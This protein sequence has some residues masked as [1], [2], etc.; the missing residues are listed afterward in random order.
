MA[1]DLGGLS[2]CRLSVYA[3]SELFDDPFDATD[4]AAAEVAADDACGTASSCRLALWLTAGRTYYVA[5]W[6]RPPESG[7]SGEATFDHTV[8]VRRRPAGVS[9]DVAGERVRD[10]R[11]WHEI[12]AGRTY[13]VSFAIAES[14]W[15][16]I[17]LEVFTGGVWKAARVFDR[18]LSSGRAYVS[19]PA[20]GSG[21]WRFSA[22]FLGTNTVLSGPRL[23]YAGLRYVSPA[24]VRYRDGGVLLRAPAYKQ[25]RNLSCEAASY[26][27]AHNY[28]RPRHLAYD[29]QVYNV[30][31]WDRRP[32]N[33]YG[34]CNPNRA[35][36][37]NVDG[38]MMRDGYGVHVDPMVRA[39]NYYDGCRPSLKLVNYSMATLASHVNN[40]H[41]VV[42]WGAHAGRTGL[43]HRTWVSW[44]RKTIVGY[45]VEHTWTVVGF[46]GRPTAPTHFTIINPSNGGT[47]TMTVAA[48]YNFI[49]YYKT[50]LVVRG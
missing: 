20:G 44:D 1:D 4:R 15:L 5:A 27:T 3:E 24:W 31:G 26:R 32:P 7:S 25:Q 8:R 45:S 21:Y 46:R 33:V 34:G 50:A 36:C 9:Y 48:F 37:G 42:V 47:Y 29:V 23:G 11:G 18:A 13:S 38:L 41:A 43:Y 28:Q 49:K 40:G 35:F 22:F 2:L 14:G 19:A 16:R 12:V 10:C 39:A 30:T 17:Y 6:S